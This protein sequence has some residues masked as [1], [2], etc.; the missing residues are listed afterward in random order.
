MENL[1]A[2]INKL[3]PLSFSSTAELSTVLTDRYADVIITGDSYIGL[4][5]DSKILKDTMA[6]LD[7]NIK[8]K[9]KPESGFFF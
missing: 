6:L 7:K 4:C 1:V 2:G 8:I 9:K 3:K 5:L